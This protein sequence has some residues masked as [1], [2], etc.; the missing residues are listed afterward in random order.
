EV[1]NAQADLLQTL[2]AIRRSNDAALN[3]K[4]ADYVFFPLSHVLRQH[5]KLPGRV[6]ESCLECVS[7]LLKTAWSSHIE[8]KLGVQLLILLTILVDPDAKEDVKAKRT[9]EFQTVVFDCF[10]DILRSLSQT[11]DGRAA[12]LSTSNVPYLG[13]AV[14]ELLDGL[15]NGP[16]QVIQLA[17][18]SAVQAFIDAV[19]DREAL[20]TSFLPGIVSAFQKILIPSTSSPRS[21]RILVGCLDSL[22]S[23]LVR[24]LGDEVTQD[25]AAASKDTEPEGRPNGKLDTPWL[26]ATASQIRM[27]LATVVKLRSHTRVEV[28]EGLLRLCVSLI[29]HCRKSLGESMPFLIETAITLEST[30]DASGSSTELETL[31]RMDSGLADLLQTTLYNWVVSLPRF[32]Q[33]PDESKKQNLIEQ[34]ATAFKLLSDLGL[35]TSMVDRTLA[36]HLRD[37]VVS[38]LQTLKS[39]KVQESTAIAT[40]PHLVDSLLPQSRVTEFNALT[41]GP[42]ASEA[43][44]KTLTDFIGQLSGYDSSLPIAKQ[45]VASIYQNDG[46]PQLASFWTS[47]QFVR[48]GLTQ[49]SDT[50]DFLSIQSS[51]QELLENLLEELYS[52]SLEL[53]EPSVFEREHDWRMQA[54]GLETI[55]LKARH[56]KEDFQNELVEA[57]YPIVHLVGSENAAL[58]QHAMTCLNVVASACGYADAKELIISNVDYLVNAVALKLNTFD[59]SPQAPQVLLMMVKL[60]GPRLLPY[61]DDLVESMFAALDSYHGYPKLVETLFG[62]LLAIAQ[63]GANTEQLAITMTDEQLQSPLR[64]T[65]ESLAENLRSLKRKREEHESED[66][67]IR[68]STSH[69]PEQ[70]WNKATEDNEKEDGSP[71]PETEDEQANDDTA[72]VENANPPAPRTYSIL[73]KISELTQHYLTSSSPSLRTSLLAMLHTTF[74]ALAKHENSFLPLINTLWPVVVARLDDQETYI[75]ANATETIACMCIYAGNFMRSRIT[76]LWDELKKLAR[77]RAELSG[78]R[79]ANKTLPKVSRPED[80]S[81]KAPSLAIASQRQVVQHRETTTY[82]EAPTRMLRES[83]INLFIA[84]LDHVEVDDDIFDD[85]LDILTPFLMARVDVKEALGRRNEDAVWLK[86]LRLQPERAVAIE[87]SKDAD[88]RGGAWGFAL[89]E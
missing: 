63:E 3:D 65:V 21:Y 69:H 11:K 31:L 7:I 43:T 64:M 82:V 14:F 27:V 26:T 39:E 80:T 2:K 51:A 42:R 47:L 70:P 35:D 68:E 38:T 17:A 73:L 23:L 86:L 12:L 54:L 6:L 28:R 52:F 20:S 32:M 4:L 50:K 30:K 46:V 57:L 62:V 79:K 81:V 77:M 84:I 29:S 59:I 88:E 44:T 55:S 87:Q 33:S 25:L 83:I 37:S 5:Q 71:E 15:S 13:K 58:R 53:V 9:E 49:R 61:L 10:A 56:L 36:S 22:T 60:S 45:L 89:V 16:S 41:L 1:G 72:D 34:I 78:R 66:L 74:P 76:G 85:M 67:A 40:T 18:L 75:V 8:P 48:S 19:D 24:V